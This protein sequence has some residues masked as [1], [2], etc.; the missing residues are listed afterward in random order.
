[1]LTDAFQDC[2]ACWFPYSGK[3]FNIKRLQAKSKEQTNVLDK[4]IYADDKT[5]NAKS[6]KNARGDGSN[7]ISTGQL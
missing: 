1:M 5:E 6:D 3:L 4:L 7:I 2:D